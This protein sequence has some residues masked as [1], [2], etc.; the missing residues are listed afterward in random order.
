VMEKVAVG[1]VFSAGHYSD[2]ETQ[3]LPERLD[4]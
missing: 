1:P 3:T 2:R 4:K